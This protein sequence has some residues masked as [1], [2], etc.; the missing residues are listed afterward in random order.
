M[1]LCQVVIDVIGLL[2]RAFMPLDIEKVEIWTGVTD[3][4]QTYCQTLKN[5]A[6]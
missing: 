1:R 6:T 2:E 5:R 4:L 3:D